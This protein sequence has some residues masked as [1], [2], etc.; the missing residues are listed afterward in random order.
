MNKSIFT[1]HKKQVKFDDHTKTKSPYVPRN[2][3]LVIFVPNAEVKSMCKN[4]SILHALRHGNRVHSDP[5]SKPN[6][7]R[8]AHETKSIVIPTLKSSQFRPPALKYVYFEHQHNKVHCDAKLRTMSF[9]AVSLWV[10]YIPA[11]VHM[12]QRQYVKYDYDHQLV[13][14]LTYPYCSE[15][16]KLL[17]KYIYHILLFATWY[18]QDYAWY[19]WPDFG[20]FH[21]FWMYN[22]LVS[23]IGR[24]L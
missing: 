20:T 16:P 22:F 9:R 18:I 6:H 10:L 1:P 8:T 24:K 15:T 4:C 13:L 21:F 14:F 23:Y 5:D 19:W 3:K 11:H 7:F 2:K 17:R 12:I